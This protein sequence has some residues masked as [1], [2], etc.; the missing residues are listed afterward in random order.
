MENSSYVRRKR[1]RNIFLVV[2][3]LL[4]LNIG[5]SYL[6][7]RVDLT[8]EKR[9][10]LSSPTKQLL[11]A[12]DSTV[13]IRVFL[14]GE[15]PSGFRH[16]AES[17]QELLEEFRRYGGRHIVYEFVNPLAGLPDSLQ[18][19][20][21]DSLT[22]MGIMPYNVQ[23]QQD[24]SRGV[25]MQL[26]FP[27]A[28]V[29]YKGHQ[30]AVDLLQP[31]P[32][33]DPLQT[34]NHSAALL[35]YA[36]AH[37]IAQL[38]RPEPPVVAYMLG[39]GETLNPEVYDAL[40]LLQ[41]NYRLDT[42]NLQTAPSISEKYA[43]LVFM[44]PTLRF[45]ES[46]KL[47]IDQYVMQGGK[48]LW[49]LNPVAASMDSLQSQSSFLAYDRDLNLED[50]L[51]NYGVRINADL[52]EDLQCFSIP[53]TV[54]HVGNRPQIEQ[55]PWPFSPLL[56]P[57]ADHPLTR[58]MEAVLG[59]FVRSMDTTV[60]PGIHKTV[61]LATSPYSRALGTPMRVSME[62]VKVKPDPRMYTQGRLPVAVLLEGIFPSVFRNRLNQ[63]MLAHIAIQF[64][65]AY[66][67]SS[68]PTRMIVIGGGNLFINA[69]SRQDGP[70]PMGMD[71]YSRQLFANREFF[72]NCL[73]YLTDTTGIISARDKDFTL[74]LLDRRKLAD[75]QAKWR[76][77]N[78]IIPIAFVLLFAL[79]FQYWRQ[80]K[81]LRETNRP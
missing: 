18:L 78:F 80:R 28:L 22:A 70:L 55:L 59:E 72:E 81:Y 25:S 57:G 17:V 53:I 43:A 15:F 73:T 66:R 64:K 19:R 79:L 31:Q 65:H 23:A 9:Y 35:E 4:A 29:D 6:R 26:I 63:Q 41:E 5:V 1:V 36:F 58:N 68:A 2:L 39:N 67:A 62:S 7:A 56:T 12:L 11:A 8:A 51:F 3:A 61:L 30:L 50:L 21:K 77:L 76:L 34:L 42:L 49:C 38:S 60:S 33:V 74:R 46:E 44:Q 16:L 14:K 54:G 13:R 24:P 52:V 71:P 27:G 40:N 48:I 69:V 45:D 20:V 75:Q 47:K 37:A 10:T 32:G